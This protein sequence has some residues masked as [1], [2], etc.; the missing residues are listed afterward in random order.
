MT[1]R[2]FRPLF[3]PTLLTALMLPLLIGLGLWQLERLEWKED[4]LARI[5]E[6]LTAAPVD[7]PAPESWRSLDL[8]AEEYRR[9]RLTGRFRDGQEL[10]YFTQGADGTPGYAVISPLVLEAG[11]GAVV[12]VDRGFVPAGLK[13]PSTRP[14]SAVEGMVSFTGVMRTPQPRGA[15]A[16]ADDP[17]KN[18]WMVRDPAVMGR[19]LGVEKVAPFIVEA[20]AD[21]FPGR[22]P[23]AGQTRVEMPNNH[24]DYALTWLG[25]AVVLLAIYLIYHRSQGRLGRPRP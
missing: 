13:D 21:A 6:R 19:A 24:L 9:V 5:T 8:E 22:W 14:D 11:Q 16:G 10:H 23:Q 7:L 12:L 20:E 18:I 1:N 15:F 4:L 25:L 2:F 3:W 17:A